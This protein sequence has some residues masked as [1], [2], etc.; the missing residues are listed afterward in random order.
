M[1][2]F[3]EV[4]IASVHQY[5][6]QLG[7]GLDIGQD[8]IIAQ[9][10]GELHHIVQTVDA[11]SIQGSGEDIPLPVIHLSDG[12]SQFVQHFH[13][14]GIV[15]IGAEDILSKGGNGTVHP[16]D[17]HGGE[18]NSDSFKP[19]ECFTYLCGGSGQ[20]EVDTLICAFVGELQPNHA[21]PPI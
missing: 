1:N 9:T 20:V 5:A 12:I 21:M 8:D 15:D 10:L 17:P 3:G 18:V 11:F 13:L 16:C 2:C 19:G 7:V 4:L 6:A 14:F